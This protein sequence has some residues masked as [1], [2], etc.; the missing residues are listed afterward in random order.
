MRLLIFLSRP[1]PVGLLGVPYAP[2]P[3]RTY[4]A[5]HM[6][7]VKA[8]F[9]STDASEFRWLRDMQPEILPLDTQLHRVRPAA[10]ESAAVRRQLAPRVAP[11]QAL[12]PR[13]CGPLASKR[14]GRRHACSH[15][16]HSSLA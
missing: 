3:P 9:S 13:V 10:N 16:P 7:D 2:S 15:S 8:A 1:M 11:P 5:G 4:E 12:R 14:S 6:Y